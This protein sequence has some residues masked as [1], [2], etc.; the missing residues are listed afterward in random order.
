[1]TH[2]ASSP[3][4]LDQLMNWLSYFAIEDVAWLGT[5]DIIRVRSGWGGIGGK[6][7]CR[8]LG[9]TLNPN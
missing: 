8:V 3:P 1:M 5:W 9:L 2:Y 4:L 7:S 6:Y